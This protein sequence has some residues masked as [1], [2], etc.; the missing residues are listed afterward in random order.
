MMILFGDAK[1]SAGKL[2]AA[3]RELTKHDSEGEKLY[4]AGSTGSTSILR[5]LRLR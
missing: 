5:S 1:Y 4:R 2:L 3:M